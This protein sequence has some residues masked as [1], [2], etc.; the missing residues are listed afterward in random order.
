M[1]DFALDDLGGSEGCWAAGQ[2]GMGE[3]G[4]AVVS[5]RAQEGVN[6]AQVTCGGEANAARRHQDAGVIPPHREGSH[7]AGEPGHIYWR[8]PGAAVRPVTYSRMSSVRNTPKL[9]PVL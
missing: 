9:A 5:Q 2:E 1:S 3:G 4:A 7:L 6:V 8:G